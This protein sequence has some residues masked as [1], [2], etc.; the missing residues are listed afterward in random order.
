[1]S[2]ELTGIL[3]CGGYGTRLE[4]INPEQTPKSLFKVNGQELISYSLKLIKPNI[5]DKL[6]F[7]VGYKANMIREWVNAQNLPF[8]IEFFDGEGLGSFGSIY[9][10]SHLVETDK[11]FACTTDEIRYG[12]LF[13]NAIEF[14][15]RHKRAMTLV[16]CYANN[17]FRHRL[18]QV[19]ERDSQVTRTTLNPLEYLN[20]PEHVGIVNAGFFIADTKALDYYNPNG[21][22]DWSGI[23]DPLCDAGQLG[24]YIEPNMSYF[25]VGTPAEYEEAESFIRQLNGSVFT[26]Y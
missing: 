3:P 26:N 9:K 4:P 23:L 10:A 13:K 18:L 5:V 6:V 8:R 12:M 7:S 20:K 1:M 11:F 15:K 16:A 17:L 22:G 19:R 14:H 25:N 21:K 24:A 2:K